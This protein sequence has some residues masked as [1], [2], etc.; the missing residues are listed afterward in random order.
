MSAATTGPGEQREVAGCHVV[1]TK[2]PK[3]PSGITFLLTASNMPLEK[4]DSIRDALLSIGNVVVGFYINSL[5]PLRRNHRV[6]AEHVREMF[7]ILKNEFRMSE[8]S[9]VGHSVGGK[10]ALMVA[11]LHD[12]DQV[13]NSVIALDPID[14]SPVEFT[15]KE[16]GNNISLKGSKA[17]ITVTVT[18]SGPVSMEHNGRAI[19]KFNQN[20]ELILHRHAGHMAYCDEGGKLSWKA[21]MGTG[22]PEKSAKA[23]REAIELVKGR[24]KSKVGGKQLRGVKKLV[25]ETKA[26]AKDF[27]DDVKDSGKKVSSGL[28]MK[29]ML[30]L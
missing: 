13:L 12:A 25:S 29:G 30:G 5:R 2:P 4:Y 14:Q 6:K 27:S 21:A 17:N 19:H 9:I 1:I 23:K 20:V 10:I 18:E 28:M 26:A 7:L 11:A 8:Y 16:L 24:A 3:S 22:N 15:N